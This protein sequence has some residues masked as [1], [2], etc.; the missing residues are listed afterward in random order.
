MTDRF[1][2]RFPIRTHHQI[3][4]LDPPLAIDLGDM[5]VR[6]IDENPYLVLRAEP[7]TTVEAAEA[8][9]PH[10]W[11]AVAWMAVSVGIPFQ[12]EMKLDQVTITTD[13]IQA[14][15]DLE[16]SCG[17]VSNGPVH[18]IVNANLPSVVSVGKNIRLAKV[19]IGGALI[20]SLSAQSIEPHLRDGILAPNAAAL[21]ADPR[22]RTAVE[23]FCDAQIEH[24]MRSQ[25]L[26]YIMALEVLTTPAMKHPIANELL[27][28]LQA[29]LSGQ[30]LQFDKDT[31]EWHALSA[32]EREILFRRDTSLRSRIRQLI[33]SNLTRLADEERQSRARDLVWAYD[34]RST[35][36]HSGTAP[37]TDVSKAHGIARLAAKDILCSQIRAFGDPK[38]NPSSLE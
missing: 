12:A 8:F 37:P 1:A 21:Y 33:L 36:I 5:I 34:V 28:S 9:L 13:P 14:A 6:V 7:F 25:F 24:S 38:S 4:G 35:I 18:G 32:L 2:L 15:L 22:L 29:A 17:L 31:E 16:R 10:L 30:K 23:L 11:G 3:T 20:Q 27:D 19:G 26:T